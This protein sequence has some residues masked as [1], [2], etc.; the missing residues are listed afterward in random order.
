MS[1]ACFEAS[2]HNGGFG[3][4]GPIT[5]V[6]YGRACAVRHAMSRVVR[7][8]ACLRQ[9]HSLRLIPWTTRLWRACW[10]R[11]PTCWKSTA[12]TASA[13]AAIGVRPKLR[14]RPLL[15]SSLPRKTPPAC[16]RSPASAK[17]WPRTCKLLSQ[18]A[19]CR[20]VRS[21]WPNTVPACWSC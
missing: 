13:S 4:V 7:F 3:N 9:S 19:L 17:A 6:S 15:T 21:S 18:Q 20:C 8:A 2:Y 14:D 1:C 16:W 10:L 11:Q 5:K 12:A